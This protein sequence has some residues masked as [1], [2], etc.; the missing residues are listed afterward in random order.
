MLYHAGGISGIVVGLSA[1]A[2][3]GNM[4][5]GLNLYISRPFVAGNACLIAVCVAYSVYV[6]VANA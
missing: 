2:V 3:L 5:S 1:Q 4:V 6:I